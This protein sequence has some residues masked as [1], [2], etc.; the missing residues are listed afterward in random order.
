MGVHC[1]Q[2][3]PFQQPLASRCDRTTCVPYEPHL[4]GKDMAFLPASVTKPA[5]NEGAEISPSTPA[6]A[7]RSF[8]M[9]RTAAGAS[10]SPRWPVLTDAAEEGAFLAAAT[11]ERR[12][13]PVAQANRSR[14]R[15]RWS[16][17][18]SLVA[19][20]QHQL[21][22]ILGERALPVRAGAALSQARRVRPNNSRTSAWRQ[23][24][25]LGRH[26]QP[27]CVPG[28]LPAAQRACS[29]SCNQTLISDW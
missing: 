3:S 22:R 15:P 23:N 9:S 16:A 21:Q 2:K 8:T 5:R 13:P 4:S 7:L 11:S 24:L 29:F 10:A 25:P 14:A 20:G 12:P 26:E 18:K 1:S 19:D 17:S 6:G 27:V 28:N